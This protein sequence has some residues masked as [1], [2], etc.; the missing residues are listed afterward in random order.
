MSSV[1]VASTVTA[2]SIGPQ[3][4][5]DIFKNL[6]SGYNDP[7]DLIGNYSRL[8]YTLSIRSLNHSSGYIDYNSTYSVVGQTTPNVVP[9]TKVSISFSNESTDGGVL[10]NDTQ[11]YTIDLDRNG[12]VIQL[13]NETSHTYL[14][15]YG[16]DPEAWLLT[17]GTE[18]YYGNIIGLFQNS[19]FLQQIGAHSVTIGSATV[20]LSSFMANSAFFGSGTGYVPGDTVTIGIGI[21]PG[22]TL[23]IPTSVAVVGELYPGNS[24]S[25]EQVTFTLTDATTA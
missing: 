6:A 16:P 8:S 21:A 13:Y 10:R 14:Q 22:T 24:S 7:Q 19:T 2:S 15:N 9:A 25:W 5:T 4:L 17:Q 11:G 20:A 1:S 23:Y 18:E 3:N 12:T